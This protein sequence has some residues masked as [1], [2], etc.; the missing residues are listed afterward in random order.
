MTD[1]SQATPREFKAF[2]EC[3]ARAGLGMDVIRFMNGTTLRRRHNLLAK[4]MRL[5]LEEY[6][7]GTAICEMFAPVWFETGL[8]WANGC[9]FIDFARNFPRPCG[10]SCTLSQVE[11]G[12]FLHAY[13][14]FCA[15]LSAAGFTLEVIRAINQSPGNVSAM[16]MADA[17]E[18]REMFSALVHVP[19]PERNDLFA[20]IT[21]MRD[22]PLVRLRTSRRRM[23]LGSGALP[24]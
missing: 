21:L 22:L 11:I 16:I 2:F 19:H 12:E 13:G 4:N 7:A 10:A 17:P 1:L 3:L 14:H 6:S 5:A 15:H 23:Q 20:P 9:R 8:C 24:L 18:N